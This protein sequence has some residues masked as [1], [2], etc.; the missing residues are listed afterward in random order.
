MPHCPAKPQRM[1]SAQGNYNICVFC[2]SNPGHDSVYKQAAATLAEGIVSRGWGFV[3]GGASVG[4]MGHLADTVLAKGGRAYGVIPESLKAKEVAHAG[5]TQLHVVQSMHE[6]KKMM[7]DMTDV[8]LT[9]PG[10]FGTFD[11]T[12]EIVT[13]KQIGLHQKPLIFLN[14]NGFYSPLIEFID[15]AV[16]AGFIKP[17]HRQLFH[18]TNSAEEALQHIARNKAKS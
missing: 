9:F 17:E 4:I 3:Y 1:Q 6:R 11:E 18:V 12:F 8:F 14:I 15:K 2:G 7:F 16:L 13:W 5:L 10:G